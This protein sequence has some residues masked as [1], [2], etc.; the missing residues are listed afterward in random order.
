VIAVLLAAGIAGTAALAATHQFRQGCEV[1]EL[2]TNRGALF[3]ARH[4]VEATDEYTP[5]DADNDQLRWDNPAWWLASYPDAPG[6]D[7][8]PNPAATIVN[9]DVPP[10]LSQTISGRAPLHLHLQVN[11]PEDL[12]L[13][14]RAYPAWVV[15]VNGAQPVWQQRTDGLIAVLLPPGADRVEIR[16]RTLPDVYAGD[17]VSGCALLV[18]GWL[19]W[20]SRRAKRVA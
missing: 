15:R 12:I 17:A 8:V 11:N 6:P 3:N 4:G 10:P 14:L 13:N 18:A 1:Q 2:P 19:G 5:F 20:R 9:Y 16:W 7:T